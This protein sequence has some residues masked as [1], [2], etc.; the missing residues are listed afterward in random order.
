MN[1]KKSNSFINN[2]LFDLGGVLLELDIDKTEHQLA[3]FRKTKM[4]HA[5]LESLFYEKLILFEKGAFSEE[6]FINFLLKH[7]HYKV[8][9]LDIINAWNSMLSFI[10]TEKLQCLKQLSK[11]FNLYSLSNNNPIHLQWIE[12]QNNAMEEGTRFFDLFEEMYFSH[13]IQIR[14]PE[15][16]AFELVIND[17]NILASETLFID[18]KKENIDMAQTLGFL[19]LHLT[20][21]DDLIPQCENLLN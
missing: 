1:K 21:M 14:K 9:A 10:T 3:K 17:S 8:Q 19:T 6:L 13:L 11:Q 16:A 7:S 4:D 12:K 2:I 15:Q 18:D 20:N 5:E